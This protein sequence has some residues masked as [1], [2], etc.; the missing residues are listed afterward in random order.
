MKRKN[1]E[2]LAVILFCVFTILFGIG[3]ISEINS[4]S[5]SVINSNT[6]LLA[7]ETIPTKSIPRETTTTTEETTTQET[8]APVVRETTTAAPNLTDLNKDK[9]FALA[10][11]NQAKANE[12]LNYVNKLRSDANI[13]PLTLDYNLNKAAAVR[14]YELH[15]SWSH[16]RPDGRRS[17]S[18]YNDLG[19]L[20]NKTI[21][22]EN[23]GYGQMSAE[24]VVSDWD[25]SPTHQ[26]NLLNPR[27]TKMGIALI[28]IDG[29]PYW[30]QTF[31][32]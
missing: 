10:S 3:F 9:A 26:A 20:G 17:F 25:D 2:F 11:E 24:E 32:D 30:A 21:L 4:A 23:L 12:V 6:D 27:F 7:Y 18:V 29:I 14:S 31:S 16:T 19:I 1:I 15:M 22:G 5:N 28:Y 13:S 8:K